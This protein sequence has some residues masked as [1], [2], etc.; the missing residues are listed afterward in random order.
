MKN[1]Q[2]ATLPGDGIGPEIIEEGVKVLKAAEQYLG[3]FH[4]MFEYLEAGA[5][6]YANTG[7]II[8]PETE[9]KMDAA[10]AIFLGAMG[11]P[12]VRLPD[13]TETQGIVINGTRK[14]LNLFAGVR[15][16]KL[17]KGIKSPLEGKND[18]DFVIIRESTEGLFASFMAGANVYDKVYADTMIITREGTEKVCD[19][20]FQYA[21]KRKGR[22]LDGKKIVTCVD[23][24]NNFTCQAFWRKIYNEVSQKYPDIERDYSFVDAINVGLIMH[25]E[26]YDVLVS[27]NIFGDI[28]SDMAAALVGG[29]GL[30]P[31]GD[32]GYDHAMFQPAHGS[33]PTIA[34]KNIANPVATIL[35]GAMMLEWLGEKYEDSALSHASG[36]IWQA[37]EDVIAS[38]HIT[39]DIGGKTSTSEFGYLTVKRLKEL[40]HSQE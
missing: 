20:A 16:I 21:R 1:Y 13:G 31:S 30:A 11:L 33:A 24:S 12:D 38:G 32:I 5:R 2:I 15:P 28:I 6:L 7:V 23:K 35:S 25:P 19:Y 9:R 18:I 39:E 34:G 14:R 36:L 27:E 3:G 4:L 22:P 8:S 10:D 40:S 17:F 29:M 37:V 26:N